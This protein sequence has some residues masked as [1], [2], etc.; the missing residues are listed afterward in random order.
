L[1]FSA[2]LFRLVPY[3]AKPVAGPL[4]MPEAV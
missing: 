2:W 1:L 4:Q 3:G